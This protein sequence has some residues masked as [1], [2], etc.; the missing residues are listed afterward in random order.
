M[1][2]SALLQFCYY[3]ESTPLNAAI[4]NNFWV[5]PFLQSIHIL[6][7]ASIL[8]GVLLINL[9][10]LGIHGQSEPI[11]AVINR[12]QSLIWLALPVLLI[13]GC[14]MIVGEPARSLTNPAFQLKMLMLLAVIFIT[15]L[16]QKKWH[17]NNS[18]TPVNTTNRLLAILSLA[19][20]VGIVAAGRWI[21]YA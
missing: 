13:T 20:W 14:I 9:R 5:V 7:I 1:Q 3:L 21:A 16:F 11:A 19:L 17:S 12:Y 18:F 10:I 4:Q 2:N 6:A 15:L 8:V